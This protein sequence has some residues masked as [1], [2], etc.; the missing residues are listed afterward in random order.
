MKRR[1]FL[2]SSASAAFLAACGGG[3]NETIAPADATPKVV[4]GWNDALLAAIRVV[5]PGPPM[6]SRTLAIL[7]T[8][9]YDAWA[10]YDATAL[11]TVTGGTLRRPEV[12]RTATNKAKAMS[13]AAY[14]VLLDQ[15][16]TERPRFDALMATYGFALSNNSDA[17]TPEGVGN[18]VAKIILTARHADGSN[19]LGNM[20]ASGVAFADYTDYRPS[21]PAT[22]FS[23]PTPLS[24]IP[25]PAH[26][27]PLTYIDAAGVTKT[28]SFI[29]PHWRNVT[30][31]SLTSAFQFRPPAPAAFDSP[32]FK[33]QAEDLMNLLLNL[34]DKQKV[35]AEYWADGPASELPPGHFCLFAQFVS[36]RDNHDND[37]DVKL[38][39]AITNAMLDAGIA[40]WEAKR[41]YDYVRPIT[42]IRFFF[43]GQTIKGYGVNGVPGGL[44]TIN[45]EAWR[46]YQPTTFPTPPF[47]EHTSGHSAFS[48]AGAEVLKQFTGSDV[49]GSSYTQAART[50]KL[51][52]TT[53]AQDVKLE[54][55][56]F[57]AAAEEA[58]MSRLYGGIHFSN[59]DL[60][61]REIGRKVG[62]QVFAKAQSYWLGKA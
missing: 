52:P 36:G 38:F 39:F 22:V 13:Y 8:A 45:G 9:M 15:Y 55:A 20:T 24:D 57:T 54:W 44:V 21:N 60:A 41:Y 35:I 10:A 46:P 12:D 16:P 33:T 56:T 50:L 17:T 51:D 1:S 5:K 49:F 6:L 3:N 29:A 61:G 62:A 28:P 43:S 53:P 25:A 58:G 14:N 26:W 7:H 59:G 37:K 18:I 23:G 32:V 2:I 4:V 27:Q 31:F 34:T 19:Q 11:A 30:P 42:A 40:S 48:S 47:A